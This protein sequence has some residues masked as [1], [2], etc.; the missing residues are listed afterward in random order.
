MKDAIKFGFKA[1]FGG[2][3]GCLGVISVVLIFVVALGLIFGPQVAGGISTFLQS[4]PGIISQGLS[5]LSGII[6]GLSDNATTIGPVPPMEV[7]LTIG[8]NPN[9]KHITT[10][11][12]AQSKQAYFWVKAPKE[13]SISF[14]LLITQPDKNKTQF[15]P[16]FKSD[17]TG[18]PIN[19]G[20]FGDTAPS[21]GS[22]KLEIIPK[23]TSSAAGSVDF[24]VTG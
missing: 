21:V 7:Y 6:P 13:T 10:F 12:A 19:C 24:K 22:Y 18:K 17:S 5:P 15:G 9:N 23:G 3:L 1:F 16:E 4:I 8:E 11:S 20:K 2:C 14:S